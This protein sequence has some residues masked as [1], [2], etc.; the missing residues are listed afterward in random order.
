MFQ[1]SINEHFLREHVAYKITAILTPSLEFYT[2]IETFQMRYCII[3][4]LKGHQNCQKLNLKVSKNSGLL[5]S[6]V[7]KS[8]SLTSGNFDA[9]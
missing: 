6:K 8:K 5:L 2:T 7:L 9:P 1:V 3:F 4:Y